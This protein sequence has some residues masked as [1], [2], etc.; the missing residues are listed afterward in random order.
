MTSL[1]YYTTFTST[2]NKFLILANKIN[3]M[4]STTINLMAE[5]TAMIGTESSHRLSHTQMVELQ[6]T[7]T[8]SPGQHSGILG[9]P[10]IPEG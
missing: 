1:R 2:D 4:D 9:C 7:A 8:S 5:I 10:V 6:L 3:Q